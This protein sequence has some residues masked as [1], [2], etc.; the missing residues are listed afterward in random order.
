MDLALPLYVVHLRASLPHPVR[1]GLKEWLIRRL[2]LTQAGRRKW[3]GMW[4]EPAV[5]EA[6]VMLQQP[7]VHRVFSWGICPLVMGPWQ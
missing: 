4:G 1:T 2:W 6:G 7:E 5:A 3:Y